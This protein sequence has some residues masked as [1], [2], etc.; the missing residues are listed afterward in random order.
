MRGAVETC[1]GTRQTFVRGGCSVL[2]SGPGL[3]GQEENSGWENLGP[4]TDLYQLPWTI[5]TPTFLRQWVPFA[6]CYWCFVY[7]F[8]RC[9]LYTVEFTHLRC[10][11]QWFL[12]YLQSCSCHHKSILEHPHYPKKEALS[13][14]A[15]F[16]PFIPPCPWQSP[17]SGHYI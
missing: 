12:L 10:T 1:Q 4:V 13:S 2:F 3:Q 5:T 6:I 9:N 8:L 17:F 15:V 14:L 7:I 16:L 11:S